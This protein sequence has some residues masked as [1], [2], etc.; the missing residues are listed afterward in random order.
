[1]KDYQKHNIKQLERLRDHLIEVLSVRENADTQLMKLNKKY[2]SEYNRAKTSASLLRWIK[3]FP[4]KII[5]NE[6][7]DVKN[8]LA[9]GIGNSKTN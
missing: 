2:S 7:E 9:L 5:D 8:R 4:L 1:M 6:I 3:K